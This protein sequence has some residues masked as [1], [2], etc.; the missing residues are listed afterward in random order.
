MTVPGVSMTP[1]FPR[2]T[3]SRYQ[4]M[5]SATLTFLLCTLP[6]PS[7][8]PTYK[9]R[10][11]VVNVPATVH[12][13]HGQ[14]I[15]DLK[16]EDF[17]L[18]EDGQ[19]QEIHYFALDADLPLMLGLLVDTSLS[20]RRVLED[21][22]RASYKFLDDMLRKE[23]KAFIIHFD[24]EAE[25]LQDLTSD[26]QSL[27]A[28][29]TDL[30]TPDMEV[31][32]RGGGGGGRGGSWPGGGGGG[33][34]GGGGSRRG[35]GGGWSGPGTVLYDAAYLAS[36]EVMKP[37]QGRKALIVLTDGVDTGSMVS[38]ER[39]IEATQRADTII[40]SILFYDAQIYNTMG[41]FGGG[42]G[43][44]GGISLP[45]GAD[46]K[47]VLKRMSEETGG[48]MF[49]VSSKLPIEK[50][51]EQIA[52]ELRN[53][54]NLGFTPQSDEPLGYHKIQLKTKQ[55]DLVV[56]ARAGYYKDR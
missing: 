6:L 4:K 41:G 50:V 18:H 13:K 52:D 53:Q 15:R 56:Q 10:T 30:H 27:E 51:Y 17:I 3:P 14:I 35:G 9:V 31:R 5:L 2:W 21:E 16:K 25:L 33:W 26:R 36:G 38:L 45:Y 11:V 46:G 55:K 54:Y 8:Q 44:P 47:K 37:L 7:Q 1:R 49:E 34:P 40:Y 12:N 22:R 23:D 29:L 32:H 42:W 39:A 19:P 24:R 48:R 43:R 28:A 20:Q